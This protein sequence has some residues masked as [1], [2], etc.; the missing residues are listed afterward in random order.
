MTAVSL[1]TPKGTDPN[2]TVTP[3]VW[4]AVQANALTEVQFFNPRLVTMELVG[5]ASGNFTNGYLPG[6]GRKF[7]Q[8]NGAP[9]TL[10]G[11]KFTLT[12]W[13]LGR[14]DSVFPI[15]APSITLISTLVFDNV[16]AASTDITDA[17]ALAIAVEQFRA[18]AANA[19]LTSNL[20]LPVAGA[21]GAS[22]AWTSSNPAVISNAGVVT[23]PASGQPDAVVSLSYVI[24]QGTE[25]TQPVAI[26][27]TVK[28]LVG[29]AAVVLF[30][31]D[32]GTV[33]KTGY[34]LGNIVYTPTGGS[35]ITAAK[36]RVQINSSTTAPHTVGN[37]F[38]V[39]APISTFLTSYIDI[40]FSAFTGAGKLELDYSVWAAAVITTFNNS[41]LA[42]TAE[43]KVQ[44]FDG[45]N[46]VNEGDAFNV[47]AN[48]S[49]TE[50]KKTSFA[51]SGAAKY[52]LVYTIAGTGLGTSN[53][54]YALTVDNLVVTDK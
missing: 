15:A 21:L 1:L 34:T 3:E 28:A 5:Y 4:T 53:T 13:I 11:K 40:D 35:E 2:L 10:R 12:G 50:Y 54:A 47:I 30:T 37:P 8:T 43:L 32:F 18:P 51:L 7:V 33:N 49:A 25:S 45:T 17:E 16:V 39:M 27:F 26:E 44:K 6:F 36:D 19:E 42:M 41:T 24:T 23:R 38:L 31:N 9:A 29:T 20:T 48:A 14:G 52:R 46:W 22:I